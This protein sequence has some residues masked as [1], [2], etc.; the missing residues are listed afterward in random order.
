[1]M[2]LWRISMTNLQLKTAQGEAHQRTEGDKRTS[3]RGERGR[4]YVRA[5][6]PE[7][8]ATP[9]YAENFLCGVH[10]SRQTTT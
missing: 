7:H 4:E 10:A 9:N 8:H 1:M 2:C 3:Q 5:H 6:C